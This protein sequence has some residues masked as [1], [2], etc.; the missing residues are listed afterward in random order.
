MY[1][2]GAMNIGSAATLDMSSPVTKVSGT[3]SFDLFGAAIKTTIPGISIPSGAV[4]ASPGTPIPPL[5]FTPVLDTP[6]LP[7]NPK[8]MLV[9]PPSPNPPPSVMSDLG[10]YGINT[11]SIAFA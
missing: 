5:S 11:G 10:V 8:Q 7:D 6:S 3:A 9:N 2:T 4:A 1:S